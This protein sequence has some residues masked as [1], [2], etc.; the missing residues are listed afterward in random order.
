MLPARR[1]SRPACSAC[2]LGSRFTPPASPSIPRATPSSPPARPAISAVI[3]TVAPGRSTWPLRAWPRASSRASCNSISLA[4]APPSIPSLAPAS[5]ISSPSPF[6]SPPL[7]QT[8]PSSTPA[9]PGSS[10][11]LGCKTTPGP[12]APAIQTPPP[13]SALPIRAFPPSP[14][15]ETK[16]SAP[17]ASRVAPAGLPRTRSASPPVFSRTPRP[18]TSSVSASSPPTM[19]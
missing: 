12:R 5:G 14:A 7:H 18:V 16:A 3:I 15:P 17:S 1:R 4:L 6:R 8:T 2:S 10:A 19:R 11:S 9:P 13:R